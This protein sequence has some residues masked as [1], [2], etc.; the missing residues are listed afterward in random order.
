MND[1]EFYIGM[2]VTGSYPPGLVEWCNKQH[3]VAIVPISHTKD[4]APRFVVRKLT[5]GSRNTIS[6]DYFNRYFVEI[7]GYGW[8]HK[9]VNGYTDVVNFLNIQLNLATITNEVNNDM[10]ELYRKP[11][12]SNDNLKLDISKYRIHTN[13]NLD[14][15]KQFFIHVINAWNNIHK[16]VI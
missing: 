2:I 13:W 10:I 9:K 6:K 7:P 1:K 11:D 15:F 8:L 14:D 12:F 5:N 4:G 16:K 3:D